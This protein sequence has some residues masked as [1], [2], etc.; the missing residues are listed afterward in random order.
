MPH[1]R[2]ESLV[3]T[4]PSRAVRAPPAD[5]RWHVGC[6]ASR[7][8]KVLAVI[9]SGRELARIHGVHSLVVAMG[10]QLAL[11]LVHGSSPGGTGH[12]SLQQ[13]LTSQ[14]RSRLGHGAESIAIFVVSGR[15]GDDVR[16]CAAEWGATAIT[17]IDGREWSAPP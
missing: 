2:A 11:C 8:M 16:A 5:R 13:Q 7:A 10:G 9:E 15:P 3:E 17:D 4:R 6:E 14:L 1:D 12:L